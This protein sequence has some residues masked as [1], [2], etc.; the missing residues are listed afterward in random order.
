[1]TWPKLVGLAL[2][3]WALVTTGL[4]LAFRSWA[5]VPLSAG[6]ALSAVCWVYGRAM[7]AEAIA[8]RDG[9]QKP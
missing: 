7:Y 8:A 1:M 3:A 6:L 9:A 5:V 2:L 4:A